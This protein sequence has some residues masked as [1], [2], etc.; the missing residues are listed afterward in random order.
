MQ[1]HGLSEE[2][3]A[4]NATSRVRKND[5]SVGYGIYA[6]NKPLKFEHS[7]SHGLHAEPTGPNGRRR[8][9][10]RVFA[11]EVGGRGW[12]GQRLRGRAAP[13]VAASNEVGADADGHVGADQSAGAL[14]EPLSAR[15]SAHYDDRSSNGRK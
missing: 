4:T 13:A 3:L 10:H 15:I 5:A 14:V 6:L 7:P 9:A 2:H 11:V 8:R 1:L 12:R